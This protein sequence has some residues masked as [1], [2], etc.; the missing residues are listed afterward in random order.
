MDERKSNF[1]VGLFWGAII[2]VALWGLIALAVLG[3]VRLIKHH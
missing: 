3:W 1:F 2:S